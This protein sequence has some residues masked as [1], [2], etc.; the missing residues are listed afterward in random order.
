MKPEA[1]D[2]LQAS[3]GA[4]LGETMRRAFGATWFCEGDYDGWRIDFTFIVGTQE[5]TKSLPV[6]ELVP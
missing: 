5:T 2:L 6:A 1:L 4:Y 3:I